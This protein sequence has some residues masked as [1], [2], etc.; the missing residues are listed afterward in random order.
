MSMIMLLAMVGCWGEP[1][2]QG[3]SG[4]S[5]NQAKA[6]AAEA[7]L[8]VHGV[9]KEI[10]EGVATV[11]VD[12][13]VKPAEDAG[14]A[15]RVA[16]GFKVVKVELR[17]PA[18]VKQGQRATFFLYGGIASN[19]GFEAEG[20][21]MP[22]EEGAL[23]KAAAPEGQ[24]QADLRKNIGESTAVVAGVVTKVDPAPPRRASEHSPELRRAVVK[25]S[26]VGKGEQALVGQEVQVLF[27]NSQ[28]VRWIRAPKFGKLARGTFLLHK[29]QMSDEPRVRTHVAAAAANL[30]GDVYSALDPGD[31]FEQ[32]SPAVLTAAPES[33]K[34][35]PL[36]K[37]ALNAQR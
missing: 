4:T 3:K 35:D 28:D 13:V 27:S 12:R 33:V 10:K 14:S 25:V 16:E 29:D 31:F 21:A 9:V 22:D 36:V 6:K 15:R 19:D 8:I 7:D 5:G 34:L 17:E 18:S 24:Q 32:K 20:E 11:S 37:A 26:E 30:Q 23:A 1:A 2:D